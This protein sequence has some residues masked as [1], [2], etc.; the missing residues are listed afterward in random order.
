MKKLAIVLLF[1]FVLATLF[2]SCK[3]QYC[4]AYED[5]VTAP[6]NANANVNESENPS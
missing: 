3:S 2:S 6:V 4:P 1:A 5:E